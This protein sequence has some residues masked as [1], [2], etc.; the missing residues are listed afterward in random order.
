MEEHT[1]QSFKNLS[2]EQKIGDK[3][4]NS[5][6]S[7]VHAIDTKNI[8][9]S[10]HTEENKHIKNIINI[11]NSIEIKEDNVTDTVIEK[12]RDPRIPDWLPEKDD[13]I[14]IEPIEKSPHLRS[15]V[16]LHTNYITLLNV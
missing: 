6:T 10:T 3:M 14:V 9:D 7:N 15:K 16:K 2:I 5:T 12:K 4:W 8:K 1:K 11:K 13:V